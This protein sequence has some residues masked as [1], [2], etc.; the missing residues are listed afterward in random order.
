MAERSAPI[1]YRFDAASRVLTGDV[2]N[3]GRAA[4]VAGVGLER[5]TPGSLTPADDIGINLFHGR[6]S[7]FATTAA[8]SLRVH[9]TPT[10]LR[11]EA[12]I[13]ER[14]TAW[15]ALTR[16][17]ARS[18]S[19]EFAPIEE[20]RD[21]TGVR[22][23]TK[24]SLNGIGL[25]DA[26]PHRGRVELRHIDELRASKRMATLRSTIRPGQRARCECS[27]PDCSYAV[28]DPPA[29]QDVLDQIADEQTEVLA[30]WA[31]YDR[32]LGSTSMNRVRAEMTPTG[33]AIEIDIPDTPDGQTLLDAAE[34]SGI[35][36]RPYLDPA[37][38]TSAI[39]GT[40]EDAVRRYKSASVR[41]LVVSA[42]DAR[43]G[44][45]VP[46]IERLGADGDSGLRHTRFM[47]R[48]EWA[49]RLLWPSH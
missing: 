32:P 37:G 35:V 2:V 8:G 4:V 9:D 46:V 42:T 25:V 38:S 21:T 18:L 48:D 49:R 27:G 29:L 44:W 26:S 47:E 24:A 41:S 6:D 3:Y 17:V 10:E 11:I 5:F 36:V 14:S 13:V 20:H 45:D 15:W 12:D 7:I 31:S 19:L 30:T 33:L 28:F 40:G 16:R 43:E 1:E 23:I 39:E 34:T 22:V